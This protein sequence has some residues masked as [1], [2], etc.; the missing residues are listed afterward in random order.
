MAPA[1]PISAHPRFAPVRIA[2]ARRH[3]YT[4]NTAGQI[5]LRYG[6]QH[7]VPVHDDEVADRMAHLLDRRAHHARGGDTV[8]AV[9]YVEHILDLEAAVAA[10]ARVRATA[11]AA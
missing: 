1:V 9:H 10:Q 6:D 11:G 5:W 8:K 4:V 3:W 2:G 7:W